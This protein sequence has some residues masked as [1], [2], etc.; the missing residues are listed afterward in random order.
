MW[1]R[2]RKSGHIFTKNNESCIKHSSKIGEGNELTELSNN[3][4][5][6][7]LTGVNITLN[8]GDNCGEKKRK[9]TFFNSLW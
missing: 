5:N 4:D 3:T 6:L 7:L 9:I 8:S 1:R 2:R